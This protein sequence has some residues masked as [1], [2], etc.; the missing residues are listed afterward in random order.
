M[1]RDD[2]D[3]YMDEADCGLASELGDGTLTML[4]FLALSG[5]DV[6]AYATTA[7]VHAKVARERA[8]GAAF[9]IEGTRLALAASRS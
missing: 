8:S 6:R 5:A 1:R 3:V 7:F 9:I 2:D 4:S